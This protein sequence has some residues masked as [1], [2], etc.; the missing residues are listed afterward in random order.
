[1]YS[2]AALH[3]RLRASPKLRARK[4]ARAVPDEKEKYPGRTGMARLRSA[5]VVVVICFAPLVARAGGV[6]LLNEDINAGAD[7]P[8]FF[9]FVRVVGGV[10]INDAKVTATLKGGAVVAASD[11]LGLYKIPG[12]GKDVNPDDVVI[13]CAKSGYKQAN[14]VRRP[15]T[16]GDVKDPIEVDCYLQKQ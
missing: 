2:V 9:G 11:I 1:L 3:Y 13:S 4:A 6:S 14:V 12:F 10:G 7:G 15:H 5:A 8:A 16:A